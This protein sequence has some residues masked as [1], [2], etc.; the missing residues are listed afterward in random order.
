MTQDHETA[1]KKYLD[2]CNEAYDLLLEENRTLKKDTSLS[3]AFLQK[4]QELL[5][6]LQSIT[7]V[8]KSLSHPEAG[9]TQRARELSTSVQNKL[10]KVL[11]L[12]RENEQLL[13][14]GA[15]NGAEPL[16]ER[17]RSAATIETVYL[18]N[19]RPRS[20]PPFNAVISRLQKAEEAQTHSE[21]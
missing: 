19:D 6:R 16:T 18:R 10:M 14:K 21:V 11:L 15:M 9:P 3:D 5:K 7:A 17:P 2:L 4:K 13:L 8:L 12:D 20:T 1:L